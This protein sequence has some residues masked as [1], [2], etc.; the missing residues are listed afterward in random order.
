[1]LHFPLDVD[2][3]VEFWVKMTILYLVF[4]GT[5]RLLSKVATIHFTFSPTVSEGS[6]FSTSLST[7]VGIWHFNFRHPVGIKCLNTSKSGS[8]GFP[9]PHYSL[10]PNPKWPPC[11]HTQ[12]FRL[13]QYEFKTFQHLALITLLAHPGKTVESL[14]LGRLRSIPLHHWKSIHQMSNSPAFPRLQV[15]PRHSPSHFICGETNFQSIVGVFSLYLSFLLFFLTLPPPPPSCFSS[16]FSSYS[17]S[18][19]SSSSLSLS[20]SCCFVFHNSR[21]GGGRDRR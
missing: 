10:G 3:E 1:M 12:Q 19:S 4:W 6:D 21:E 9:P 2:L 15:C 13:V 16:S 5:A 20:F 18:S 8:S 14:H 11:H 17:S 7:L